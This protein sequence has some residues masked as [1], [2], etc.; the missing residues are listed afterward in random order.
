MDNLD[1]LKL[2]IK[3]IYPRIEN[4]EI[5]HG[6]AAEILGISKMDFL[7]ICGSMGYHYLD[8]VIFEDLKT[9]KWFVE[10]IQG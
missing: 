9:A 10:H 5:S 2:K 6:R 1:D 3:E 8:A 7:E 4:Q